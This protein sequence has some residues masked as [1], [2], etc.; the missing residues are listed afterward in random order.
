MRGVYSALA[1]RQE[2]LGHAAIGNAIELRGVDPSLSQILL[3]AKPRGRH[4]ADRGNAHSRQ[5]GQPEVRVGISTNDRERVAADDLGEAD[6]RR[7]GVVVVVLHDPHRACPDDFGST[8][9]QRLL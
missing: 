1:Q 6:E 8:V 5:V 2:I 3:Q 4:L 9:E 7:A